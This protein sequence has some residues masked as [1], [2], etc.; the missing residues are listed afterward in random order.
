MGLVRSTSADA[1]ARA[2]KQLLPPGRLWDLSPSS[3]LSLVML[4]AGDELARISVRA[5]DLWSESD[6]ASTTEFLSDFEGELA[7][8][9]TGTD[10]ERRARIVSRL[11]LRQRYRPIDFQEILASVLGYTDPTSVDVIENDRAFAISV[12]DDSEIFKFYIYRDPT[13][14]GSYDIDEA[15]AIVDRIKPSHTV[16]YVIESINLKCDE[17]TSLCDRDILGV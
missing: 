16:G 9:S 15:Q 14:P 1:F 5:G 10:A 2:M 4:S 3:V 7:I 12:A 8:D 17:A 6:P 11:L 13:D